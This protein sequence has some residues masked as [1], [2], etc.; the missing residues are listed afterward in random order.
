[1]EKKFDRRLELVWNAQKMSRHAWAEWV[2]SP[3]VRHLLWQGRETLKKTWEWDQKSPKSYPM[4]TYIALAELRD[5][6]AS[7]LSSPPATNISLPKPRIPRTLWQLISQ[8][9]VRNIWEDSHSG[10]FEQAIARATP[11]I[12]SEHQKSWK[13]FKG[14]VRAIETA[15][16]V[17]YFGWELLPKP[18]VNILHKGLNEIAKAAGIGDQH[19]KGFA[20]FLDDLCPCGLKK[21]REAVRKGSSRSTR[22]RR[23]KE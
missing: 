5:R 2:E 7:P 14:I 16:L 22:M 17:D 12:H 19:E 6:V 9:T 11:T 8:G 4:N 23:P 21:H 10:S 18:K 15:Y 3:E 20:E 13:V 1:M